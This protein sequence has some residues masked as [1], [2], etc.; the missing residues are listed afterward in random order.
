MSPTEIA[1]AAL[2]RPRA[3]VAPE[4]LDHRRTMNEQ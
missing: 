2:V 1:G 3:N 4:E